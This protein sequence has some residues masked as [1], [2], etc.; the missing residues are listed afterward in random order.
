M[1]VNISESVESVDIGTL[2]THKNNMNS[3]LSALNGLGLDTSA[4]TISSDIE[5]IS[6][7]FK[8]NWTDTVSSNLQAILGKVEGAMK[9]IITD[10]GSG[11]FARMKE[12]VSKLQT[13]L[14]TCIEIKK[15]YDEWVQYK[16]K[17]EDYKT[18]L[19]NSNNN[20]CN[21]SLISKIN[22]DISTAINTIN[23]LKIKYQNN[24]ISTNS[25]FGYLESIVFNDSGNIPNVSID[26]CD[27]SSPPSNFDEYISPGGQNPGGQNPGG[28]NPGGQ[29]PGGQNPGGQNPGGQNPGGQNPGGQD[30]GGQDPGGKDP[31]DSKP[32]TLN[33]YIRYCREHGDNRDVR[34]LEAEFYHE[35]GEYDALVQQIENESK[36]G[37][38]P[39]QTYPVPKFVGGAA[40][41]AYLAQCYASADQLGLTGAER[42]VY[43]NVLCRSYDTGKPVE[44]NG[45]SVVWDGSSFNVTDGNNEYSSV[46]AGDAAAYILD[47]PLS[48]G[49]NSGAG[50]VPPVVNGGGVPS[51]TDPGSVMTSDQITGQLEIFRG[52]FS[53]R[54]DTYS[55]GNYHVS[56]NGDYYTLLDSNNKVLFSDSDPSVL[57]EYIANGN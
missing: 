42:E 37:S 4:N 55:I 47:N 10:V 32:K 33:E 48:S 31:E 26:S 43:A 38:S 17:L 50:G 3:F 8:G 15:M 20:G 23:N 51:G 19:I 25:L 7:S 54:N 16:A 36:N 35:E 28:Q 18:Q 53:P 13:F 22:T 24:A 11:G 2:N 5:S 46:S 34:L 9:A 14:E 44:I 40:A 29:N 27:I 21:D 57:A 6:S 56:W 45:Y 30:P 52:D 12:T 1:S 39:K 41:S 49:G